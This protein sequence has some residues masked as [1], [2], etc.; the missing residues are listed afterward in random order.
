MFV[1][2]VALNKEV[3]RRKVPRL[4]PQ[5]YDTVI[6]GRT[7][8]IHTSMGLYEDYGI[9]DIDV[10]KDGFKWA[11]EATRKIYDFVME[12]MPMVSVA[13]I[14]FTG[15]TSFH[16]KCTFNRKMKSEVIRFLFKK[17]LLNSDLSRIY[18]IGET[19]KSGVPNIDLNRNC[20]RCNHITLN[21]LSVW[22]L[23]CTEVP[24]QSLMRFDPRQARI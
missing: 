18:S 7:L 17:F 1:I 6:T 19:R 4:T 21:A 9:L 20:L 11:Q 10:G 5:N 15:K 12:K 22:G 8:S 16:I 13:Q 3:I 14:R 23:K 2:M 24:Y